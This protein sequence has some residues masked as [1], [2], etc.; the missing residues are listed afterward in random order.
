MKVSPMNYH[1]ECGSVMMMVY[2]DHEH[3]IV[4]CLATGCERRGA[5]RRVRLADA[6]EVHETLPAL[7]PVTADAPRG[8]D[9]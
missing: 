6:D 9:A 1:C 2:A 7:D 5:R 3:A 4:R 8:A